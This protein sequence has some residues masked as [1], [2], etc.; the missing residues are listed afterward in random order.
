MSLQ[1]Q[2]YDN[3]V[4]PALLHEY[5]TGTKLGTLR[6]LPAINR[7]LADATKNYNAQHATHFEVVTQ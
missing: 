5:Q 2:M 1:K 4:N 7:V 3:E 6:L